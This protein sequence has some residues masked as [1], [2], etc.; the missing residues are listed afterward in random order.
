[1][2]RLEL[3]FGGLNLVRMLGQDALK[4]LIVGEII[5]RKFGSFVCVARQPR[6]IEAK[7]LAVW[8]ANVM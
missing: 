4:A 2:L 8:F 5:F 6:Q 3:D 1:M 7:C